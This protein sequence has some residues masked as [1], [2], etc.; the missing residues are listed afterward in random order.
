[1][2]VLPPELGGRQMPYRLVRDLI[3]RDALVS[4]AS[5]TTVRAAAKIMVEHV[6][7]SI[8]VTD[9]GCLVGIFTTHDLLTRVTAARRDPD[10]TRLGEIMTCGPETLSADLPIKAATQRLEEFGRRDYLPVVEGGRII[11]VLSTHHLLFSEVP[12]VRHSGRS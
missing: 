8:L 5:N 9:G 10:A 6:C 4:A 1:M 11:G 7:G 3:E 2:R 12:N